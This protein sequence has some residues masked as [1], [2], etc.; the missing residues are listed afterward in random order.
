MDRFGLNETGHL[1]EGNFTFYWFFHVLLLQSGLSFIVVLQSLIKLFI[2][3]FKRQLFMLKSR[4]PRVVIYTTLSSFIF[5]WTYICLIL[6]DYTLFLLF[7]TSLKLSRS[8]RTR[9]T[10]SMTVCVLPSG[11]FFSSDFVLLWTSLLPVFEGCKILHVSTFVDSSSYLKFILFEFL[12]MWICAYKLNS[13]W[14]LSF[15]FR[16]SFYTGYYMFPRSY[17]N[18]RL[19]SRLWYLRS[20]VTLL[21]FLLLLL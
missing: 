16:C 20:S 9:R 6:L 5:V 13:L 21:T 1:P 17:Y 19:R 4:S 2:L 8:L 10:N 14:F 18:R 3:P 15:N 12:W 7:L 11:T